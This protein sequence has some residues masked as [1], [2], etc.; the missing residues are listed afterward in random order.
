MF[1]TL[2]AG[3]AIAALLLTPSTALAAKGGNGAGGTAGCHMP[4]SERGRPRDPEHAIT[5]GIGGT[6]PT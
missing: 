5:P 4:E 3:L 1:R 6:T 2:V